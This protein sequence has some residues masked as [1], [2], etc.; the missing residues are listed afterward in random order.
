MAKQTTLRTNL[1]IT[2]VTLTGKTNRLVE[3]FRSWTETKIGAKRTGKSPKNSDRQLGTG[4]LIFAANDDSKRNLSDRLS[5]AID[6]KY[7]VICKTT[8][9]FIA[10]EVILFWPLLFDRLNLKAQFPLRLRPETE[11]E[12]A[13]RLFKP[14]LEEENLPQADSEYRLIR[15]SLD[16][17]QLAGASCLEAEDIPAILEQGLP[18]ND[19]ESSQLLNSF[20]S[21]EDLKT[22]KRM[23]ELLLE[24]RNWCLERGLLTYGLI[25]EL[26][27]RY[28]LPDPTYQKHL[29][30]RTQAIFADDVDDYP[31]IARN[32]FSFLLDRHVLGVFTY[33]PDGMVRVGLNADPN[34]LIGLADRCRVER[35]T[36]PR[37]TSLTLELSEMVTQLVSDPMFMA[38][39]PN[40]VQSIQTISRA[41]MLRTAAEM[42]IDAINRQE[43]KPEEIAIIAPGLDEI[44]RYT[45][46]NILSNNH[47]PVAP[48][49]E[50]RPLISSPLIRALLTLLALIYNGLGRLVDRDAVAEMLVV[51]SCKPRDNKLVP[52]I[53]PVRAGLLADYCY[54]VDLENPH[55]LPVASF[56]RWDRLGYRAT[57]AYQEI[58]AWLEKAKHWLKEERF[59][60]PVFLLDRAIKQLIDRGNH[61]SFDRLSALRELMETAQHYW[62]VDRR[63]RLSDKI[64]LTQT[65]IVAQFIQL[66]RRGTITANPLPIRS[67]ANKQGTVTLANIFQYRSLRSCHRW[68]FWLDAG[69][70]LWDKGGAA[71]LFAAPLFLKEWSGRAWLPENEQ[72][73]DRLRL[74]R[75]IR[76]LLAR[77]GERVYLCHSDLGVNGTEQMGPLLALVHASRQFV[78]DKAEIV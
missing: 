41:E 24:W 43:V 61:L 16:L 17:L 25:Y 74:E 64:S 45:L 60:N 62:E 29:L 21:K 40:A 39:L 69:S 46:I 32:L 56:A 68:Q 2:G 73:N 34:Y 15:R 66:L 63:V 23:G 4:A 38:T 10:D 49:N 27:W 58:I 54:Q 33:N 48:L 31:A 14:Y 65:E 57:N 67:L 76:D 3:E 5:A 12:L 1:W 7:P 78:V 70:P 20:S 28:L 50:Q 8:L 22:W 52:N 35:L 13:T 30:R 59:P 42:A 75:I 9:G 6:G 55:L 37:N 18:P 72:I 11:Q 36:S 77:T 19:Y 47:I 44:A 51:L 26:Y 53:D 71:T